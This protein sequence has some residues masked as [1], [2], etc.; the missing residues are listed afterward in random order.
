[1]LKKIAF[2]VCIFAGSLVFAGDYDTPGEGGKQKGGA[3][4][5]QQLQD[6]QQRSLEEHQRQL[7]EQQR[8]MEEQQRKLELQQLQP[9]NEPQPGDLPKDKPGN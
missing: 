1:M 7:E 5:E 4:L 6:E 2:A 9:G 8:Q 3:E